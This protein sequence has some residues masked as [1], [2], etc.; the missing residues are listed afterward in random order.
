VGPSK[1]Q[2]ANLLDFVS[3]GDLYGILDEVT[4]LEQADERLVPFATKI[5]QLAKEYEIDK[6]EQL[7]NQ[8]I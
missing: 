6:I 4:Q 3:T 7:I 5:R 2:L 8:Y 1:E